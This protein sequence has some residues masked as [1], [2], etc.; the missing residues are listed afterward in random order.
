MLYSIGVLN[1]KHLAPSIASKKNVLYGRAQE[2]RIR[3]MYD[4]VTYM[5]GKLPEA[6]ISHVSILNIFWK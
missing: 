3:K 2:L 5:E 4:V 1:R 6:L